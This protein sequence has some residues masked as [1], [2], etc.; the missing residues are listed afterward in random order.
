M[1]TTQATQKLKKLYPDLAHMASV[2][3]W[4]HPNG[5]RST[6]YR[7]F[8][9]IGGGCNFVDTNLSISMKNTFEAHKQKLAQPHPSVNI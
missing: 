6:N 1:T 9:S 2:E 7:L 8:S 4:E 3:S 5:T